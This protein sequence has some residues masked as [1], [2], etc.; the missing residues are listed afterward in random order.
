MALWTSF[1][2]PLH[3]HYDAEASIPGPISGTSFDVALITKGVLII[4][5]DPD[6][7]RLAS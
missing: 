7:A 2:T 3:C 6:M 4:R 1:L 5:N